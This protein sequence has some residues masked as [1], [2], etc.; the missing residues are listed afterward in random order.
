LQIFSENIA[1]FSTLGA[2][3]GGKSATKM[4][5]RGKTTGQLCSI[6][7]PKRGR[8]IAIFWRYN[9]KGCDNIFVTA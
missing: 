4:S 1:D 2:Y 5:G 3:L 6:Q 7:P 9:K 8:K